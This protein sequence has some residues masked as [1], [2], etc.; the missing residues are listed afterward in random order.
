MG[1]LTGVGDKQVGAPGENKAEGRANANI[2]G[3]TWRMLTGKGMGA[4]E[5]PAP[6]SRE[7]CKH[8][9]YAYCEGSDDYRQGDRVSAVIEG[10]GEAIV[11]TRGFR[12]MKARIVALHF[13]ESVSEH[14]RALVS[15]NYAG[16][17]V[18]ESFEEMVQ[19]FPPDAAGNEPS[20]ENDPDFWTRDV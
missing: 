13:R 1:R 5:P 6:H 4:V 8:G 2:Y 10:Y 19:S 18:F 16:V 3:M 14:L 20:P 15:R 7:G 9:F 12:A 17:P 11:G